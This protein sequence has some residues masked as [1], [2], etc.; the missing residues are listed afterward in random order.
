VAADPFMVFINRI[1]SYKNDWLQLVSNVITAKKEIERYCEAEKNNRFYELDSKTIE[2]VQQLRKTFVNFYLIFTELRVLAEE[3]R[4]EKE[5]L[6]KLEETRK[7]ILALSE[8][9]SDTSKVLSAHEKL[10][11]ALTMLELRIARPPLVG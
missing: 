6:E 10:Y 5:F 9:L 8:D 1:V 7:E 4:M 2:L 11:S 3:L